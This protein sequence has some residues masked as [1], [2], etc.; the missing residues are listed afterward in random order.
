MSIVSNCLQLQGRTPKLHVQ[1]QVPGPLPYPKSKHNQPSKQ[2]FVLHVLFSHDLL[3]NAGFCSMVE[4]MYPRRAAHLSEVAGLAASTFVSCADTRG[5]PEDSAADVSVILAMLAP[6]LSISPLT[7]ISFLFRAPFLLFRLLC[8]I[9]RRFSIPPVSSSSRRSGNASARL[10]SE[11][12][13]FFGLLCFVAVFLLDLIPL[14]PGTACFEEEDGV[15]FLAIREEDW[16][17]ERKE[18]CLMS[19]L[20]RLE[21]RKESEER[22]SG[23]WI[24]DGSK[25]WIWPVMRWWRRVRAEGFLSEG[26]VGAIV[27]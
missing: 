19:R 15:D 5:P 6:N 26:A 16:T 25:G 12:I 27:T 4:E 22:V 14:A 13:L 21:E 20:S 9:F 2:C 8:L 24:L 1:V 11:A 18:E 10:S 23:R 17:R 7:T 3:V